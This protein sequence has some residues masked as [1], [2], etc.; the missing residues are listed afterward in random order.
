MKGRF[1]CEW[2]G[3]FR[4]GNHRERCPDNP[5]V[6]AETMA[7]L[8]DG[9]GH[10][11]LSQDYKNHCAG[12]M[13]YST[14][15]KRYGSWA[16]VA[17]AFGLELPETY[18]PRPDKVKPQSALDRAIDATWD[19]MEAEMAANRALRFECGAFRM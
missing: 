5:R 17:A 7:A 14:L 18:H 10:I 3:D 12:G 6:H 4:G 1:R 11:R 19:D 16:H 8:D 13:V 15:W 9:T 2:C